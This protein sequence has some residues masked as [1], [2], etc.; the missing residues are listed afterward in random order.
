MTGRTTL[1]RV[2]DVI[3]P[4]GD[5]PP[6][7][8]ASGSAL[9]ARWCAA[10]HPE[11]KQA[12]RVRRSSRPRAAA[13]ALVG[14]LG[15]LIVAA[16]GR[17]QRVDSSDYRRA[18]RIRTFDP[19]LVGGRVYPVWFR[20]SVRFYFAA[21]GAGAD[22]GTVY[23]V[24]PRARTKRPLLDNVRV[25]ASLSAAADTT[26]DPHQLPSGTLAV[27][28]R[29]MQFDL[30]G[31]TY[32]CAL[33]TGR[34]ARADAAQVATQRRVT[35]PA[36]ASR[37]P[38]GQWDA[39]VWNYNVYLRPARLSDADPSAWR[40]RRPP[41]YRTG[42]DA[43][44]MPGPLPPRD[45]V[46][47]PGGSVALTTQGT[48]SWGFGLYHFGLEVAQVEFDRFTPAPADIRW[49]PDSKRLLIRRDDLRGVRIYPLY[50]STSNQPV[51]HSYF[52]AV[53][54]D[55]AVPRYTMYVLDVAR[56][57]AVEIKSAPVGLLGNPSEG[58]WGR[59]SNELY[60]LT[61]TRG[62]KAAQ[63]SEVDP[64]SGTIRAIVRDSAVTY[65]DPT[66]S[67]WAVVNGGDDILWRS[68]RD[69]WGHL[70]RYAKDGTL[71]NQ[72]E[73]GTYKVAEIVRVDSVRKQVYF[74]AWGKAAGVP[75][76]A[77]LYRVGF[78]GGNVVP[79]TPEAG[80][81]TIRPVP[82]APYFL[83]TYSQIGVPPVT[84]VR[85]ANGAVVLELARGD[86]APLRATAWTPADVFAV[87]ARDAV[88]D[89]WGVLYK[90][91][92][93]D[94]TKRYPVVTYIY[95][96]PQR[97]S[98]GDWVFKGPDW[99]LGTTVE[100][101]QDRRTATRNMG[102]EGMRRALAELGFIVVQ[103]DAMGSSPQRSK[104]FADYFYGR[105]RDNG[106]PDQVAAIRQLAAKYP[107]I[108]TTRVGI[109]GH[110]GGGYAAGAAMLHHPDF[111]KVGV[112]ASG[113][114][115]FRVYG[116]YWGEK[117]QGP[118]QRVGTSD[119]YEA[120]ANYKYVA[121]LKGKLLL[122]TGDMDCNNPPAETLRVA[123][124]LTRAGKDFDLLVVPDAGHQRS[125][126]AIKRSWDYFVR[127]LLGAEPPADYHMIAP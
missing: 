51:D 38:D 117:F 72:L 84:V 48:P 101:R 96:G 118:Y 4:V 85:D 29:E 73:R 116:W 61:T 24:D 75:H 99:V 8:G 113:N 95:P 59:T 22:R 62:M 58:R 47:L 18:D 33:A 105:A 119:N 123:D 55:S 9:R 42:C 121:N 91:S 11:R 57:A 56:R 19:L 36:W 127:N 103:L 111:F 27:G 87:K 70:Y 52:Y 120:E 112:S 124:A 31:T 82:G 23:V 126:Y 44:A 71:K 92:T 53:P 86:V 63:L 97:G 15:E 77:H 28:E 106:L 21:T 78:D 115:D 25:A 76:Y 14:G 67:S 104:A 122:M 32:S 41:A 125:T 43:R 88:T 81:H 46:P 7:K 50:S 69:G 93:F 13:L 20:D 114:H 54:G 12:R 89:L 3:D 10:R 30:R 90:P 107:W 102:E 83:D 74:T 109:F 79:L 100:T 80:N 17:A 16:P 35:G 110:S 1:P 49:S 2:H 6:P 68:E 66:S 5:P 98:V 64:A 39:F 37:S 60:L 34:C 45:S 108:D 94:P 65:V 40:P 26:I